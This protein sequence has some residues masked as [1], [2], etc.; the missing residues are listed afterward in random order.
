MK[1]IISNNGRELVSIE[2]AGL[3]LLK[4]DGKTM[5]RTR[6]AD[7]ARRWA[8]CIHADIPIVVYNWDKGTWK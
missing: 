4:K 2:K 3:F 5:Q 6:C 8:T 7:E 1:T